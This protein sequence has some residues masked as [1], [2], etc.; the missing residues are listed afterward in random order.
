MAY[1]VVIFDAFGTILKI[2]D[3][4][5]PYRQLLREG[6]KHGRRP[7]P[8]DAVRIM[9]FNGSL[10]ACAD[11]LEIQ[12]KPQRLAEIE[13]ALEEEVA[14]I[15]AFEDALEAVEL[16][17]EHHIPLG[18]C[19][20]LAQ[21]YA[22]AVRRHFPKLQGY[23]FSFEISTVKPDPQIYRAA[24]S[25]LGIELAHE[26]DTRRLVMIGDS[27][28]CDCH[29]PRSVGMTGIHLERSLHGRI[30]NLV[31]FAHLVIGAEQG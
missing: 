19:S 22:Q 4:V 12:I 30:N 26:A 15:E 29:G 31:D 23:T 5:H 10:S 1:K 6:M 14:G 7:R 18:V 20:N 25:S 21:P 3:G 13:A 2:Q 24:C 11:A 27:L 9:I 17:R 28:R 16:L 8:D